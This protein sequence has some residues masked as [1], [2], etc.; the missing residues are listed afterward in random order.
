MWC[1]NYPSKCVFGVNTTDFLSHRINS[2]GVRPL[3]GKVSAIHYY[4]LSDSLQ[5]LHHFLG[6]INFYRRFILHSAE[7]CQPLADL[8]KLTQKRFVM[9][10]SDLAAFKKF[11]DALADTTT[12]S[13]LRPESVFTLTTDTSD[14]AAGGDLHQVHKGKTYSIDFFSK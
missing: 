7:L 14:V 12:P 8:L 3:P 2:E 9:K 11:V 5:K 4:P 10:E 13:H 1:G 6:I